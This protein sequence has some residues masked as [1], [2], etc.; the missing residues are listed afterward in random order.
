MN[1]VRTPLGKEPSRHFSKWKNEI[2]KADTRTASHATAGF[3]LIE[4]LVVIAIIAILASMLLPAL[5]KAKQK[6]NSI[7][8]LN[9]LHQI[10]VFMQLYVSDSSDTFPAHRDMPGYVPASGLAE[11]NWWGEYIVTYG[12]GKSNLFRC[13]GI[14]GP[15]ENGGFEWIFNRDKVGYGFNSYFL[16]AYPQALGVD[17]VNISGFSYKPNQWFKQSSLLRPTDTLSVCD[18][19]PKPTGNDSF[20]AWWPKAA[21]NSFGTDKEGVCV[22]RHS[23]R[24]NVV[25]T[26]SHAEARKDER[27]NPPVDPLSGNPNGLVNSRYWDPIQRAGTR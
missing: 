10:G 27:I 15:K 8:C 11:N 14:K 16:G 19:D 2:Q 23:L 12:G 9:N 21:I 5:S 20:S 24:G 4:L 1:L 18:Q 13:P 25:F 6:A 7:S 3:T 26:D 22:A 17:N